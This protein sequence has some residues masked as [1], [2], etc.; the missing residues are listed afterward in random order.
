MSESFCQLKKAKQILKIIKSEDIVAKSSQ[1]LPTAK[2]RPG[3]FNLV[4]K[5]RH[6]W[7]AEWWV[8]MVI[9][10][11]CPIPHV[12]CYVQLSLRVWVISSFLQNGVY[13]I[14]WFVTQRGKTYERSRTIRWRIVAPWWGC[15][16]ALASKI[17]LE[18]GTRILASLAWALS[19]HCCSVAPAFTMLTPKHLPGV[20]GYIHHFLELLP[21]F[22]RVIWLPLTLFSG[23]KHL[24]VQ[25]SA[26]CV[27]Q[28]SLN[29]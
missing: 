8:S 4:S 29:L 1:A 14:R 3:Y 10:T 2:V 22:F 11:S 23:W 15:M 25:K 19:S 26:Q 13:K 6:R 21:S 18:Y 9:S 24:F 16:D 20:L 12:L 5:F 17:S 27:T 7:K 28:R